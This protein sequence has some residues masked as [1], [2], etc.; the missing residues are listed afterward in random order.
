MGLKFTY[1]K[2]LEISKILKAKGLKFN[3]LVEMVQFIYTDEEAFQAFIRIGADCADN[4]GAIDFISAE[5]ESGKDYFD[6]QQSVI[7]AL[8]EANFYKKELQDMLKALKTEE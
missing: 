1:R 2:I 6:V 7:E 5:M 3:Q 4:D 8:I